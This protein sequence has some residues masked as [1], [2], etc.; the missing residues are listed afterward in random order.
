MEPL[1]NLTWQHMASDN[2]RRRSLERVRSPIE[3][4]AFAGSCLLE[5]FVHVS[6][7]A[8]V[9]SLLGEDEQI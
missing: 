9:P 6:N 1:N 8:D 5:P 2:S 7:P 3:Y 4:R